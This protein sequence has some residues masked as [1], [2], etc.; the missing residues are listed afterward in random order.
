MLGGYDIFSSKFRE[1]F[2]LFVIIFGAA[3]RM[4]DLPKTVHFSLHF[5]LPQKVPFSRK[6]SQKHARDN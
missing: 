1:I 3:K 5:A 4:P 2:A 6:K